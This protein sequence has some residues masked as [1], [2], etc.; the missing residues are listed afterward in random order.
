MYM[1]LRCESYTDMELVELQY[2]SSSCKIPKLHVLRYHVVSSIRLYGS[3]NGMLMETYKILHKSNIKNLYRM[4][5]KEELCS[6][7]VKYTA[8][9]KFR[10]SSG[11]RNLLWE[12]NVNEIE[13]KVSQINQ[14][15][16]IHHLYKEGFDNL[17]TGFEEF[18]TENDINYDDQS[19][20][21]KIYLSVAIKSTDIVRTAA[22][23]YGNE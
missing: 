17:C 8:K 15:N 10:R 18:F 11:F 5:N 14:D 6:T 13:T 21:F 7:N 20:Y 16:D 9:S 3:M 12:F 1:K 2:S 23:F 22:S 19:G 4:I